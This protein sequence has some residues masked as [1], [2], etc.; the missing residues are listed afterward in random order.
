MSWEAR[1]P[2]KADAWPGMES[3]GME[4][5]EVGYTV[6]FLVDVGLVTREIMVGMVEWGGGSLSCGMGL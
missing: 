4:P 3:R 2:G 1:W 5:E 6:S